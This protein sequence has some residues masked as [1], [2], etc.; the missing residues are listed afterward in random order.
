MEENGEF[1]LFRPQMVQI[2][3]VV[4]SGGDFF[5]G[6]A[7]VSPVPISGGGGSKKTGAH[8][9]REPKAADR[10]TGGRTELINNWGVGMG[11]KRKGKEMVS[12]YTQEQQ[13]GFLLPS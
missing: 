12:T 2:F 7:L 1:R 3:F 5:L 6:F 10:R 13:R 8:R 11:K 4:S 9:E